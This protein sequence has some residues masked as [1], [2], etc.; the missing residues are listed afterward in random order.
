MKL[1][2]LVIAVVAAAVIAAAAPAVRQATVVI[3]HRTASDV[4][5]YVRLTVPLRS[6][7]VHRR[8]A[9]DLIPAP[10]RCP[11]TLLTPYHGGRGFAAA[12][13]GG[14]DADPV[15]T[16]FATVSLRA[17]QGQVCAVVAVED[18]SYKPTVGVHLHR[19]A[20]QTPSTPLVLFRGLGWNDLASSSCAPAQRALVAQILRTP[21][22][23]EIDV[24]TPDFQ[25]GAVRGRLGPPGLPP[26]RAMHAH[27]T[28]A[29]VCAPTCGSG[30]PDGLG[31]AT[32]LLRPL[33]SASA[34]CFRLE[35][36]PSVALPML[37]AHVHRGPLGQE[38]PVVAELAPPGERRAMGCRTVHE[39]TYDEIVANPS[40]FYVDVHNGEFPAGAIRGQLPSR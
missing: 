25:E 26:Q 38:G 3:C 20:G 30:D 4:R 16:G 1:C 22:E 17:G 8:H 14:P 32:V 28:G 39:R 34:I 27:M 33:I 7:R 18:L 2:A 29:A 31:G 37:E 19:A 15:A 40:G 5:L 11:N 10:T 9:A 35:V 23:F 21:S 6:L 36:A 13:T 12:L 24:H